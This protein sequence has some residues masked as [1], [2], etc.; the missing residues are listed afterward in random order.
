M[1]RIAFALTLF[2][3]AIAFAQPESKS[4]SATI[5]AQYSAEELTR[6]PAAEARQG[7]AWRWIRAIFMP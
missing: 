1:K 6:W 5:I 3:P 4:E 2:A 7:V